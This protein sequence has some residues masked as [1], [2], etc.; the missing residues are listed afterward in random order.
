MWPGIL[1]LQWPQWHSSCAIHCSLTAVEYSSHAIDCSVIA[2]D[3]SFTAIDYSFTAI[4][5]SVIALECNIT[6]IDYS[7]HAID[8]TVT[9]I[10]YSSTAI[11]LNI[12]NVY[13][14]TKCQTN[15]FTFHYV[16][17]MF[18]LEQQLFASSEVY[19]YH[20]TVCQSL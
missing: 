16:H 19:R 18:P 1:G 12:Y 10:D 8:C 15:F 17:S 14:D 3:C 20:S 2:V 6:A 11:L 13:L 5:Y 9:A 4:G 7:H